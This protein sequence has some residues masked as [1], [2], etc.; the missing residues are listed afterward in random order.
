[1]ISSPTSANTTS[2]SILCLGV[3]AVVVHHL[4]FFYGYFGFDDMHYA[5]LASR[6]LEGQIDY[7]D[8]YSHRWTVLLPTALS[9][10]LFGVS[11][12]S[13]AL[14]SMLCSAATLALLYRRFGSDAFVFLATVLLLFSVRWYVFYTDKLMPTA[15]LSLFAFWAWLCYEQIRLDGTNRLRGFL[16]AS[17]LLLAFLAKG[18]I[19]LIVPLLAFYLVQDLR[20]KS[21]QRWRYS[22][23]SGAAL[24]L[25]YFVATYLLTGNP[26][27]R[28]MAIESNAYL[29]DCSYSEMPLAATWHRLTTGFATLMWEEGL[30]KFL[31]V[32]IAALTYARYMRVEA[33][34]YRPLKFYAATIIVLFLSMNFMTISLTAYNPTCL[35]TRH[36]LFAVPIMVACAGSILESFRLGN[37]VRAVIVA[38]LI[39]LL[40]PS[41]KHMMYAKSL[42]YTTTKADVMTLSDR[43]DDK[44]IVTNPV[45]VN[46]LGF[47]H[48]FDETKNPLLTVDQVT[49]TSCDQGCYLVANWYTDYHA[50]KNVAAMINA[51]STKGYTAV[52]DKEMS[53]KFKSISVYRITT[54]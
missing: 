17:L 30:A 33:D 31:V 35:D 49:P 4:L 45:M 18:T 8:H 42:N 21:L 6:L 2:V 23:W 40:V 16:F 43:L 50:G 5:K 41:V 39:C 29:N 36:F 14:P 37:L 3:I 46:L 20:S 22:I 9:Y 52:E 12:F 15:F 53:A 48:G 7:G 47:Y 26:L 24:L 25:L 19:I 38:F 44:V 27:T 54:K 13:T 34:V 51:L 32:A 1:M 10:Y 11:D 28:F